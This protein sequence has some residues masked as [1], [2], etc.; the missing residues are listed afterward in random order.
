MDDTIPNPKVFTEVKDS[1][2]REEFDTGSLRDT[3]K[4]KPR[5]SLVPPGPL[6]RLAMH[7]TNGAEKYGDHNWT[8]GQPAG[9]FLDSLE[10]HVIAFKEG[11]D[12]EDHL[13]AIAWNSFALM[14]FQDRNWIAPDGTD[15]NNLVTADTSPE[16]LIAEREKTHP[17][18]RF[19]NPND[20]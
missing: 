9:R 3:Q 15:L 2:E 16:R 11:K 12:D 13:A 18:D 1:G 14:Y 4:G 10:R 7:Y 5:F 8:L 20:Q 17:V 6:T 19:G